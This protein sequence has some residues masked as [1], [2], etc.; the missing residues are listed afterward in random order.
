ME[1]LLQC[2]QCANQFDSVERVPK[3][4][5]LCGHTMCLQCVSAISTNCPECNTEQNITSPEELLTNAKLMQIVESTKKMRLQEAS[6]VA[7]PLNS[8]EG[9]TAGMEEDP[10]AGDEP[11]EYNFG[12]TG[13]HHPP[14]TEGGSAL[15]SDEKRV[16]CA[17]HRNKEIEYFCKVCHSIVCAKCMF[18]DH[19]GHELA[20]LEDVTTVIRQN[21]HDL[22]KLLLNAKR[23]NDDNRNYVSYVREEIVRLKEQQFRNIDKGFSELIKRLEDKR[24]ELKK[25]FAQKYVNE[26]QHIGGKLQA[27]DQNAEEIQHIEIIYDELIKFVEKN[28]DAKILT[29]ISDVTSFISQS[30]VDLEKI[31]RS[32][33]FEKSETFIDQ[34][35]KPL[36]LNV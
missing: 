32:K 1:A 6:Q 33:G 4:L 23:I 15:G 31:A 11:R 24:E 19:N 20:Q 25:D 28:N 35:L 18:A 7:R 13:Q 14:A 17:K 8:A 36:T 9:H 10:T 16:Y 26:E 2:D 29:K 12:A 22:H 21:I 34:S 5:P 3:I 30:I 27:L